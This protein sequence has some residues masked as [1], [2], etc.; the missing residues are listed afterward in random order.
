MTQRTRSEFSINWMKIKWYFEPPSK[1][2]RVEFISHDGNA[3]I[4][5]YIYTCTHYSH[6]YWNKLWRQTI[7]NHLS[8]PSVVLYEITTALTRHYLYSISVIGQNNFHLLSVSIKMPS[9]KFFG[10]RSDGKK[11]RIGILAKSEVISFF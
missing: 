6:I 3:R 5:L 4:L 8:S 1:S 2:H 10:V 9:P 11:T 7:Q